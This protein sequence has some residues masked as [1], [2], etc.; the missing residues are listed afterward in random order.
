MQKGDKSQ[1]QHINPQRRKTRARSAL[2]T[3]K[4]LTGGKF[5]PPSN[6]PD[7][8]AQPWYPLVLSWTANPG[9]TTF[10][11][12]V[13]KFRAEL[14]PHSTGFN[15]AIFASGDPKSFRVQFRFKKVVTWNLTGKAISLTIYDDLEQNNTDK[16]QL[17]GWTD[18]G[19][20]SYFPAIGFIYP[21]SHANRVHRPDEKLKDTVIFQTTASASSDTLLMHLSVLWRFDG[22]VKALGTLPSNEERLLAA[23]KNLA[24]QIRQNQP[25][26]LSRVVDGVRKTASLVSVIAA[27][28]G[29]GPSAGIFSLPL[30]VHEDPP[31]LIDSASAL[32]SRITS[33]VLQELGDKDTSS[34]SSFENEL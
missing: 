14:D 31:P 3:R 7:V 34:T 4:Q 12:L 29:P 1:K 19:G 6:P 2:V 15:Q 30:E 16:D 33:L 27:P 24:G 11:T 17:G 26:T 25:S 8:T 13:A 9:L 18:C 5:T 23:I 32:V 22:S 21:Y 20:P 28:E 10:S